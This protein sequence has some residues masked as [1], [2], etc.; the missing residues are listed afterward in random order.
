MTSSAAS[1][2]ALVSSSATTDA[3]RRS[4]LNSASSPK[5]LPGPIRASVI[6]RP[7]GK[8]RTTLTSPEWRT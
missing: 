8:R 6:R 2:T 7:S 1:T 4:P 3:D 5:T